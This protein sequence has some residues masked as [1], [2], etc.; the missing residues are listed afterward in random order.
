MS[1]AVVAMVAM[2]AACGNNQPAEEPAAEEAACEC[3]DSCCQ[4][5]SCAACQADSVVVAE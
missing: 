2:A 4:C 3:C 1:L 5:D